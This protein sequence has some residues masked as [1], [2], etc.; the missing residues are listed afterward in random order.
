MSESVLTYVEL[1]L[2]LL[3]ALD[4]LG[5]FLEINDEGYIEEAFGEF[6]VADFTEAALAYSASGNVHALQVYYLVIVQAVL[7]SSFKL[8]QLSPN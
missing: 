5:T 8:V 6:M 7:V 1:R 4:R 3:G 2:K